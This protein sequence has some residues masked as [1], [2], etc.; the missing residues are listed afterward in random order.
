MDKAIKSAKGSMDKK[1]NKLISMDKKRDAKCE[2][3]EKMMHK[4]SKKK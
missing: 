1:M 4:K 3:A 2:K